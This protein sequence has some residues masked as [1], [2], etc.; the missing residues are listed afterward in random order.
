MIWNWPNF[1]AKYFFVSRYIEP[2]WIYST[3]LL[4]NS[5]ISEIIRK[6]AKFVFNCWCLPKKTV[7]YIT[8]CFTCMYDWFNLSH[9]PSDEKVSALL[10]I[11]WNCSFSTEESSCSESGVGSAILPLLACKRDM[12]SHL[13][14]L[15]ISGKKAWSRRGRSQPIG[16]RWVKTSL[17]IFS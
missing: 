6:D 12:T 8:V 9:K 5:A 2:L 13:V 4:L 15:G 11:C 7:V 1:P 16:G 3:L 10:D 17:Y 14:S